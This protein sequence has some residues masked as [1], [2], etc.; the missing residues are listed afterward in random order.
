MLQIFFIYIHF[1]S[2]TDFTTFPYLMFS[3]VWENLLSDNH[4]REKI[5]ETVKDAIGKMQLALQIDKK[6][7]RCVFFEIES[8]QT[9]RG[10]E[11]GF[12]RLNYYLRYLLRVQPATE[13]YGTVRAALETFTTSARFAAHLKMSFS[14]EEALIRYKTDVV[15]D[16]SF[17]IRKYCEE[18]DKRNKLDRELLDRY[19]PETSITMEKEKN[20]KEKQKQYQAR[21]KRKRSLENSHIDR[22]TGKKKARPSDDIETRRKKVCIYYP[23]GKCKRG[24]ACKFEHII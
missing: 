4:A 6:I 19:L 22:N 24:Q 7:L 13:S 5:G 14:L 17:Q 11:V 10:L 16:L 9:R 23:Q 1:F 3:W 18:E 8:A 21:S 12:K 15:Q 20:G 2:L